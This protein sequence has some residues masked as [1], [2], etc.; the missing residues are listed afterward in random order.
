MAVA[1]QYTLANSCLQ[2]LP[3]L[4]EHCAHCLI[5]QFV[6]A[7]CGCCCCA[8]L[9]SCVIA[10]IIHHSTVALC[11]TTCVARRGAACASP[12]LAATLTR[13]ASQLRLQSRNP[14]NLELLLH[15]TAEWQQ[16]TSPR[17]LK[18]R[19][20]GPCDRLC[21]SHTR[22]GPQTFRLAHAVLVIE[23]RVGQ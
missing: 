16:S 2:R 19:I 21:K 5:E 15:V 23:Q 22:K 10:H 11:R 13:E 6:R 8:A 7:C 17:P 20:A 3:R 18:E 12:R 1:Y 4:P 14:Q 9:L